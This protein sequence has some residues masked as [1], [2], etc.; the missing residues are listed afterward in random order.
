MGGGGGIGNAS[1]L[2]RAAVDIRE[3]RGGGGRG[4]EVLLNYPRFVSTRAETAPVEKARAW[5]VA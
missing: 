3:G 4:G 1:L 2:L 5:P